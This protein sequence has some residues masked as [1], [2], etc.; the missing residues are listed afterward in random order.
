M[1]SFE[2]VETILDRWKAEFR[3]GSFVYHD[4]AVKFRSLVYEHFGRDGDNAYGVYVIRRET[5]RSIV[6]VGKGGTLAATGSIRDRIY[7]V[8]CKTSVEV[9]WVQIIGSASW[10][11][12]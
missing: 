5:E 1:L 8:G 9:M 3:N 4:Q 6:Y 12:R 10:W 2:N 11:L 7:R